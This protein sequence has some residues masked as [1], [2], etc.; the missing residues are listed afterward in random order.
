MRRQF[1]HLIECIDCSA[2]LHGGVLAFDVAGIIQT[3]A[4]SNQE[5]QAGRR[6]KVA[7]ADN[8]HLLRTRDHQ[9]RRRAANPGDEGAPV[10]AS[11]FLPDAPA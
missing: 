11:D 3:C 7:I 4:E 6:T 1:W 8:R 5:Q 10:L 2:I 9:P